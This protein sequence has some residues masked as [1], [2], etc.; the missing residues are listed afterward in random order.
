MAKFALNVVVIIVELNHGFKFFMRS[1]F[2]L[3]EDRLLRFRIVA[4]VG[5]AVVDALDSWRVD[6]DAKI[7]KSFVR[8]IRR[9]LK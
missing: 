7:S 6:V 4:C 1:S 5:G 3:S 8:L 2:S 9:L